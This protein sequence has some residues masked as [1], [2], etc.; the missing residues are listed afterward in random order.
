VSDL[1]L[2]AEVVRGGVIESVHAGSLVA[3]GP[4][5]RSLLAVGE[6]DVP[7]FPRSS[8]KPLQAVGMLRAGLA[9]GDEAEGVEFLALAQASHSGEP[10]HLALVRRLLGRAGLTESALGNTPDLPL[11]PVASRQ[12]LRRDGEPSRLAQNCSG[13]HA[14]MLATCVAREWPTGP[15]GAYLSPEHPLQGE[16]RATVEDL[17]GQSTADTVVDG[18]GAPLWSVSLTGLA[19]AFSA[20]VLGEPGTPERR[21]ADAGRAHPSVVGGSGR[22]VTL[23][24]EQVPGLLAKD[25]A[26]GVYAVALADGTAVALKVADGAARARIPVLLEVLRALGVDVDPEPFVV[27]VLGGG[28]PVGKVRALSLA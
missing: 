23:L 2:L 6:V 4:D 27:P 26:E 24:M 19:R 11:D 1:P 9:L 5:G 22:D 13:K 3:V 15:A 16:L 18:C 20:L 21:V 14:A 10:A 28:R 17:C 7:V 12:W 8:L 25:G